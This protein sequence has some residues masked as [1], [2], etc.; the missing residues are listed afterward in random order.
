MWRRASLAEGEA[1]AWRGQ[2]ECCP[3]AAL[4]SAHR[5]SSLARAE[6]R[7]EARG[8][9][10]AR[11]PR[12]IREGA[13][14]RAAIRKA[15]KKSKKSDVLYALYEDEDAPVPMPPPVSDAVAQETAQKVARIKAL[16]A[17][18]PGVSPGAVL[19]ALAYM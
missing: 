14:A 9:R 6:A 5:V 7:E 1:A 8:G 2:G 18:R 15:E 3:H 13:K 17:A 19:Q 4:A 16:A 10:E 11:D 12:K